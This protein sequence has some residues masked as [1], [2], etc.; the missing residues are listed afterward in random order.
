M[1]HGKGLQEEL[2][3]KAVCIRDPEKRAVITKNND[4]DICRHQPITIFE[5]Y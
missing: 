3:R 4:D 2:L 5:L 1:S